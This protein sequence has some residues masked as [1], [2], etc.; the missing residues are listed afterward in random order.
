MPEGTYRFVDHID[1][2]GAEPEPIE[3]H[4]AVTIAGD[5]VAI[6]WTG[7][8]AQV[9]GGINAPIPFT[10][11]AAYT[12][13]R[14]VMSASIPHAEGFTRVVEITAPEGTIINPRHPAACGARGITGLRM[15]DCLLGALAQAVPARV[16]ADGSD[17]A[18]L[19]TIGGTHEGK[20]FVFVETFMGNWGATATHDGQEGMAALGANQSNIPVELI[21]LTEPIRIEQYG[22]VSD[23]AGP[24]R[25]R[26]GLSVVRDYRLLA[27]EAVLSVRS[28]K[29]RFTPH[30]LAGGG[31]GAPSWNVINPG[32]DQQIIPVLTTEPVT[33][34][35][36]D[37]F[38][39]VTAGSG[40]V[41]AGDRARPRCRAQGRDRRQGNVDARP[42]GLWG[43]DHGRLR[44]RLGRD[45]SPSRRDGGRCGR[46]RLGGTLRVGGRQSRARLSAAPLSKSCTRS[47]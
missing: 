47:V 34:H 17:G 29:R 36:N 35:K 44:R 32:R 28:D 2:L 13:L 41:R 12:A 8:S 31:A 42:D 24:G 30:G 43:R 26:G 14:C 6:D 23:T 15:I 7:T 9:K 10:K 45:P 3:F 40:G 25:F 1:G 37:V 5:G 11:A 39:H 20:P 16:P 33:M 19:P 38:R 21:E 22:L 46:R 18:C 27:D 4:V